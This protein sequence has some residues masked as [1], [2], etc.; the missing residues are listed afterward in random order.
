MEVKDDIL[1]NAIAR[2]KQSFNT[3]LHYYSQYF[4]WYEKEVESIFSNIKSEIQALNTSEN[5][6]SRTKIVEATRLIEKVSENHVIINELLVSI[7][8][9][10]VST[11]DKTSEKESMF[12]RTENQLSHLSPS[13]INGYI[14]EFTE[15]FKRNMKYGWALSAQMPFVKYQ[16]IASSDYNKAFTDKYFLELFEYN[17]GELYEA[18]KEYIISHSTAEWDKL[19]TNCFSV[20]ENEMYNIA[21]PS[22]I[23]AIEYELILISKSEKIG[24]NLIKHVRSI[25]EKNK[26]DSVYRYVIGTQL[27]QMLKNDIFGKVSFVTT[28][29]RPM[30]INRNLVLHGRDNPTS[31]NK[32][33]VFKLITI[34]SSLKMLTQ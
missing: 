14:K 33:E 15:S 27:L 32:A 18:E 31:W 5:I 25:L 30:V 22:L 4:D 28:E 13:S 11:L 26:A 3:M 24:K 23:V 21:I 9:E 19:Y 8:I 1:E 12:L 29:R 34:I 10:I 6:S 7:V 20:I 17:N 2:F 16:K